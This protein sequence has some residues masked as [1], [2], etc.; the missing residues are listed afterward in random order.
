MC[1]ALRVTSRG[2]R[3][4][5]CRPVSQRQ[6]DDMVLVAHIREQHKLSLHSYGRPRMTEELQEL[7]FDVGNRRVGRLMRQNGIEAISTRKYKVTTDRNH[8]FTIAANLL[9]RDFSAMAS[10][11]KWAGDIT[12]IW[13]SEGW[14]YLAVILDLY[15]LLHH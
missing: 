6:R 8:S 11:Q 12:Y 3:A 2:Y 7:G 1:R 5:Q 14:L 9:D 15:S 4:W 10:N 13:T